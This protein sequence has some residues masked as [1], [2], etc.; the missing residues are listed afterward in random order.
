MLGPAAQSDSFSE[1][2]SGGCSGK[3]RRRGSAVVGV[4]RSI[5]SIRD[6]FRC[7]S[8]I[9]KAIH[10]CGRWPVNGIAFGRYQLQELIGEGGMGQVWRAYDTITDR[11]VAIKLLPGH[12]AIDPAFRERFR[13]EAHDTA[14]LREPHVV[15]IHGYGEIEGHLYLD[16]RLIDGADA[17]TLLNRD[18]AMKPETAVAVITQAAAAL[19]AAHAQRLVHRDVKPSNLLVTDSGFV[20]LID[21][22][23]ARSASDAP[24]TSTS[25]KIGTLAYM[26]PER[27]TSGVADARSD[28]YALTCVLCECLTGLPPYPSNSEEQQIAAHL[29]AAPPAPSLRRLD[30]PV[31]FDE[32]VAR[33]MAKNPEDRY[34]TAGELATAADHA[35]TTAPAAAAGTLPP[36]AVQKPGLEGRG[37]RPGIPPP[38]PA[39]EP[40]AEP[41][42]TIGAGPPVQP[43]AQR[44]A[45]EDGTGPPRRKRPVIRVAVAVAA[46][47]IATVAVSGIWWLAHRAKPALAFDGRYEVTYTPR[48]LN[49]KPD[50]GPPA[51]RVWSVR[52]DCPSDSERCVASITSQ[53]PSEP[54]KAPTQFVADYR[55]GAWMITREVPPQPDTDCASPITNE[56]QVIPAWQRLQFRSGDPSWSGTYVGFAGGP[57]AFVLEAGM[58]LSRVG[59]IDPKVAVVP[60]E[61]IPARIDNRPVAPIS[62]TYDVTITYAATPDVPDPP[63]PSKLRQRY[64][65]VCLRGGDRCAAT[66]QAD[67]RADPRTDP[68][69][70]FAP[71]L[72]LEDGVWQTRYSSPY[73]CFAGSNEPHADAT[74]H[75]ELLPS[76]AGTDPTE[77]LTGTWIR[78]KAAPC[79]ETSRASV[80]MRRVGSIGGRP[81]IAGTPADQQPSVA[82]IVAVPVHP[83]GLPTRIDSR[84]AATNVRGQYT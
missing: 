84:H 33:G 3:G 71:M 20:Y 43:A 8:F 17:R 69:A 1:K 58:T 68:R 57:C 18:G 66:T 50:A 77:L 56:A 37:D 41:K 19:D 47:L 34:P 51:T 79:P 32:V 72:M 15:P 63:R 23:I 49:G 11:I 60:P 9:A 39:T 65:T 30:L 25:T 73:P 35:L 21:F 10:P 44:P 55:D 74:F 46:A 2:R 67:P 14:Q 36:T 4:P 42:S 62:G 16:M 12:F 81:A 5:S 48:A 29:T 13:R 78:D 24:L 45:R 26:A 59:E 54:E 80:E 6:L 82:E 28:V 52:S 31:G 61:T 76:E 27:F 40:N 83:P 22:G 75:W 64:E 53:N 7:Y 38:I 70:V